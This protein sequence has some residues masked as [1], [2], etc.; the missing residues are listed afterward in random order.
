MKW[1]KQHKVLFI[2]FILFLIITPPLIN[3]CLYSNIPTHNTTDGDW[4][5]FWGSYLSGIISLVGVVL[6]IIYMKN[7]YED[8][9]KKIDDREEKERRSKEPF[10]IPLE[11]RTYLYKDDESNYYFYNKSAPENEEC[12]ID[13]NFLLNIV[14]VGNESA[15]SISAKWILPDYCFINNYLKGENLSIE[16]R[17]YDLWECYLDK[18]NTDENI[19]LIM[20]SEIYNDEKILICTQMY[21]KDISIKLIEKNKLNNKIFTYKDIPLGKLKIQCNDVLGNSIVKEYEMSL[22]LIGSTTLNT[23]TLIINF[24]LLQNNK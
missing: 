8:T 23:Y 7:E 6:T 14:N 3:I 11:V 2:L 21:L 1:I 16:K 18:S 20:P 4:L 5:G 22:K 19:Q 24:K 10:L 15:L 12:K 9:N 13:E 17:M